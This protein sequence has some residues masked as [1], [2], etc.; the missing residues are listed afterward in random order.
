MKRKSLGPGREEKKRERTS[1][2]I[3]PTAKYQ[4]IRSN[5]RLT[6][7]YQGRRF[8]P[9]ELEGWHDC[10]VCAKNLGEI[11]SKGAP[12]RKN[13][14]GEGGE[15]QGKNGNPLGGKKNTNGKHARRRRSTKE[16][17][18]DTEGKKKKKRCRNRA[19]ERMRTHGRPLSD[20]R[21][22]PGL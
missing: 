16:T 3:D 20:P 22:G 11:E 15:G 8:A 17:Q 12:G 1:L 7:E 10:R 21:T 5:C 2:Q 14:E 9:G 18:H 6:K 19:S 13:N 4:S